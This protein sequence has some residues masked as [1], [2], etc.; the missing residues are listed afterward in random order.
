MLI[1]NFTTEKANM[2]ATRTYEDFSTFLGVRP[3]RIGL[4]AS[5][6]KDLTASALT[7]QLMNVYYNKKEGTK[8]QPINSLMFEWEIDTSY[9]ER[10]KFTE[11][12]EKIAGQEYLCHFEKRYYERMDTFI[13]EYSR[14][15]MIV[16]S[17][18]TRCSD[19]SWEYHCQLISSDYHQEL[20]TKYCQPGCDTR[21]MSNYHPELSKEGYTK[22]QSNLERHRNY[23][24]KHRADASRSALY[25]AMEDT[26][27]SIS[28]K[29]GTGS[30]KQAIFRF[31]QQ[32]KLVLDTFMQ[33]RNNSLLF[34]KCNFDKNG[35]CMIHDPEDGQPIPMGKNSIA[36]FSCKAVA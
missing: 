13:I 27:V 19:G 8:F 5:L 34:G 21:W 23:I 20:D 3:E 24:S 6:Y 15:T 2:S 16:L 36:H 14:Q 9:I 12:P 25:G 29:D 18:P 22:F 33:A 28:K 31:P 11:V 17:V 32:E 4:A 30:D 1:A 7:E 10:I 35:K 26:F